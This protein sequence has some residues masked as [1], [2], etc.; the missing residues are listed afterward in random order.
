MRIVC[1]QQ[2]ARARLPFRTGAVVPQAGHLLPALAAVD[3]VEHRRVFDAGKHRVGIGQRRLEMPDALELPGVR[4]AVVPLVR[5]GGAVVGELVVHR[6]PGLAAVVRPLNQ[7]PEPAGRL[8]RVQPVRVGRRSLEVIDLPAAEMRSADLPLVAPAVGR[9]HERAFA[10]ANEHP[11]SA[12]EGVL[13]AIV[14][15]EGPGS[16]TRSGRLRGRGLDVAVGAGRA[17]AHAGRI[18][19][20][21]NRAG[22]YP[23][24]ARQSGIH[25]EPSISTSSSRA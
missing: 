24:S 9:R 10:C 14:D 21:Q 22:A 2:A 25:T 4:R 20:Q 13:H 12:H 18:A 8:R 17:Q 3:R 1:R 7:L 5:A 16:T 19:E 15:P 11:Y 6:L 23:A